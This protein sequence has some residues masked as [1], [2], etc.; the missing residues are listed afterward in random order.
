M[1]P[2]NYVVIRTSVHTLLMHNFSG[3]TNVK[4][5]SGFLG[6]QTAN[7][8]EDSSSNIK[9]RIPANIL[10]KKCV[11][12]ESRRTYSFMQNNNVLFFCNNKNNN[13]DFFIVCKC[14]G[15]VSGA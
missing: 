14:I 7:V 8:N 4:A 5:V 3:T 13:K 12:G 9:R 15:D 11:V 6:L 10:S 2:T 1:L